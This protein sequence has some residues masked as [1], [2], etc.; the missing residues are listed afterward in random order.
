[1]VDQEAA[2]GGGR[3]GAGDPR[4]PQERPRERDAAARG[5]AHAGRCARDSWI[6]V[7]LA[8]ADL[9]LP[10]PRREGDRRRTARDPEA[11]AGGGGARTRTRSCGTARS[12][13]S[14]S[15]WRSSS[16]ESGTARPLQG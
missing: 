1:G 4:A 14:A 10:E 7:S 3:E 8:E 6:H 12:V 13:T 9:A 2:Q 11:R 5:L 15:T 16:G